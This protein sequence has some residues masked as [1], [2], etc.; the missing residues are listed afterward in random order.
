[1]MAG[2]PEPATIG[3]FERERPDE[4]RAVNKHAAG[5]AD[6][7]DME[8]DAYSRP[9]V[10]LEECPPY[11]QAPGV[12]H[13]SF[14]K[15]HLPLPLEFIPTTSAI[16]PS[17]EIQR[18]SSRKRRG[19]LRAAHQKSVDATSAAAAFGNRPDDQ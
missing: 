4:L 5:N 17:A 9:Q 6:Q 7:Q 2:R 13:P 19:E 14:Q 1:M 15:S 11:P 18:F 3:G 12:S 8:A 10:N 16:D